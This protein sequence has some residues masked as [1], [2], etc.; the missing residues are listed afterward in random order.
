M[1]RFI[2]VGLVGALVV[3]GAIALAVVPMVRARVDGVAATA[4]AAPPPGL[5]DPGRSLL[6][7]R[8]WLNTAPLRANDLRGK[9]VLVNFWTY[10]CINSLRALPYIRAW[11]AKY[12]DRGLVVIGVHT[13]EFGFEKDVDNVR[14][15]NAALGV[16]YPL[17]SRP[18]ADVLNFCLESEAV[19]WRHRG[20][21][22][23]PT[24]LPCSERQLSALSP[25][26][27]VGGALSSRLN[28]RVGL[29]P[30]AELLGH[31]V[32]AVGDAL[33]AVAEHAL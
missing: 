3:A 22:P 33:L 7:A 5:S 2:L 26:A 27:R 4:A 28:E 12:K 14:R 1:S 24:S 16:S 11:A 21:C 32:F 18:I 20:Q 10:S 31:R 9:V 8:Q 30:V 29:G 15:A 19:D 17:A 25:P 13:P 23:L 6:G